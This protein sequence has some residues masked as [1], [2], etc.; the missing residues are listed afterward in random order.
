M[1]RYKVKV[2]SKEFI[3]EIEEIIEEIIEEGDT[4]RPV[5][6]ISKPNNTEAMAKANENNVTN[7]AVNIVKAPMSGNI[8]KVNCKPKSRVNSGDVLFV[9]EAMKMENEITARVSGVIKQVLVNEGD[10]VKTRQPL[11]EFEE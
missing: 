11:V 7:N 2:N 6:N 1:K 9:L 8:L 4:Q 3:V 5:Q 10:S